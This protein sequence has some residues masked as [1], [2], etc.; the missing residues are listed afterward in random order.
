MT[1]KRAQRARALERWA[2]EVDVDDLVEANTAA[3]RTI[4]E[5]VDQRARSTRRCSVRFAMPATLV[6]PGRRSE[7]CLACPSRQPNASTP[8]D[9]VVASIDAWKPEPPRRADLAP[10]GHEMV[11]GFPGRYEMVNDAADHTDGAPAQNGQIRTS[12]HPTDGLRVS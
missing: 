3:L 8:Q 1:T 5:L 11:T 6:G 12:L 4:A 7:R 9:L 10:G 2:D